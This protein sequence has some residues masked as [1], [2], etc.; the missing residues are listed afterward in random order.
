MAARNIG[1]RRGE[2]L[3]VV[4]GAMLG[5]AIITSSFVVGD[6]DRRRDATSP[7]PSYGPIDLTLTAAHDA[8]RRDPPTTCGRD[9][10]RRHRR[11]R[12]SAGDH[13]RHRHPELDAQAATSRG[14][15]SSSSTSTR[16]ARSGATRHHRAGRCA[17]PGPGEIR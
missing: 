11:H 17:H 13:H 5:T 1:R 10:R 12:R 2:A 3:L 6:V 16:P 14:S 7:E 4:A 8:T 15:R 9:P